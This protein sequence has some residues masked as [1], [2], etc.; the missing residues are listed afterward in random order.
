MQFQQKIAESKMAEYLIF[1]K[2]VKEIFQDQVLRAV[3]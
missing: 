2:R 3:I 1:M